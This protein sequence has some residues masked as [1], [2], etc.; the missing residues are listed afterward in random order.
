MPHSILKNWLGIFTQKK[1]IA[2]GLLGFSTGIPYFL[3]ASTLAIWLK[4]IG[5]DNETIAHYAIAALPSCV[6][7]LWAP[8]IDRAPIP[9]LT[10][11]FGRRRAWL[12]FSQL[13]LFF[14]LSAFYYAPPSIELAILTSF[15]AATQQAVMLAY[16]MERLHKEDYGPGEAIGVMGGRLGM[17]LDSKHRH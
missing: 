9:Y 2:I 15:F 11:R 8:F 5:Y 1:F 7:F 16:Q 10:Q 6:S 4:S 14:S 13:G 12:L 17:L 3:T